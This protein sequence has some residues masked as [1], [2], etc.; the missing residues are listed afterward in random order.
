MPTTLPNG[1]YLALNCGDQIVDVLPFEQLFTQRLERRFPF[2]G[3]RL[4][5]AVVARAQLLY[6][7]LVLVSLALNRRSRLLE[8]DA[9]LRLLPARFPQLANLVEFLVERED[10]LEQ[11]R[12]HLHAALV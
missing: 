9:K 11:R 3:R 10:L 5:L 6:P 2:G 7:S 4:G 12:R 1:C 8:P